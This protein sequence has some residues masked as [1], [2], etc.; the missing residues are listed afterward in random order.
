MRDFFVLSSFYHVRPVTL[1]HMKN[2]WLKIMSFG[3]GLGLTTMTQIVTAETF[4]IDKEK[5]SV[6]VDVKATGDNFTATLN[7]YDSSITGD[8]ATKKPAKVTFHWDFGDLATGKEKRDAKML[9]W[10]VNGNQGDFTLSSFT[11]RTDG[12]MW[13]KGDMTINKKTTVVEFPCK[14]LVKDKMMILRGNAV[15]DTRKFDLPIIKMLKLFTVDP[16]VTV[17]F[18]L[19]GSVK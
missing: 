3:F 6:Q 18:A 17:K 4:V 12:R 5:S 2:N 11:K 10:L 15:L 8:L 19:K 1:W 14:V 9:E 13:A 7:K 16:I